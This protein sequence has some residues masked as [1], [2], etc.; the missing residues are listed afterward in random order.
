MPPKRKQPAPLTEAEKAEILRRHAAGETRNGIAREMGRSQQAVSK[1]VAN[2]G[3]SFARA[4]EVQAAT[5]ARRIDLEERRVDLAHQ[6]HLHAER[7]LTQLDKPALVYN[8]GGKDNT[9]EEHTL[10][11]PSFGDKRTIIGAAGIAIDKSLKLVPPKTDT[12]GLAAVDA[13]LKGMMGGD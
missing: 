10:P 12:E 4:V 1:T 8:F 7:L 5:E 11:E 13:W 6:L 9:Y 2:A 3:G